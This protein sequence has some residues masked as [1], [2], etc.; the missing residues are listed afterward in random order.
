[1][2]LRAQTQAWVVFP[3]FFPCVFG[4]TLLMY[5]WFRHKELIWCCHVRPN[6]ICYIMLRWKSP[7]HTQFLWAVYKKKIQMFLRNFTKKYCS[8]IY[9][10][11]KILFLCWNSTADKPSEQGHV[12]RIRLNIPSPRLEFLVTPILFIN[13]TKVVTLGLVEV[14]SGVNLA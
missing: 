4:F 13:Y 5:L 6:Q 2:V 14:K 3:P 1:M 8:L 12:V 10:E 7:S 9:Y 11:R